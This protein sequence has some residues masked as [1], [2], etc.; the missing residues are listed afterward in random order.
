M[1]LILFSEQQQ[2]EIYSALS[3]GNKNNSIAKD[4]RIKKLEE[5]LA[6][7]HADMVSF[8][9]EQEK[10]NEELQSANEEVVSSNEELQSVNEELETSKEEIESSNEELT[11]TNQELHTRNELLS[12]SYS[13]SEAITD[14]IHE[15]MIVLDKNLSIKSANK[16]FYKKF[17]V[18][19]EET[20]GMLL[21]DLANR[22]WNIPSL[23]KLLEDIIPKNSHF[24]DFELTH[25]FKGIGEKVMLLNASRIMQEKH[26]EQL[27]LL[28]IND[29]T[30][31]A[32]LQQK[33]KELLKKDNREKNAQNEKLEIAVKE[34]TSLLEVTNET[35]EQKINEL[36]R[37]NRELQA[38]TY[39]SS[40]DL[41]EPLRKIK[42]I[43]HSF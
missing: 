11:T 24:H 21:Y 14:T 30:E 32:L 26:G 9:Q 33:E 3:N 18:K 15:P 23:R 4:R 7:A 27:I 6:G 36:E 10:F 34:R 22:Q 12:E 1:L 37:T 31:R 8:I 38:F 5:E 41:Q 40:H 19:R 42:C 25:H 29:I 2:A 35:L 20:E 28:A 39:I 13:Y 43:L 17:E 16:A